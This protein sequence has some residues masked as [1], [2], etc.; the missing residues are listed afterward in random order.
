M[1]I[2]TSLC[3][4]FMRLHLERIPQVSVI[5]G[6]NQWTFMNCLPFCS[7][8]LTLEVLACIS[9]L[10]SNYKCLPI[11]KLWFILLSLVN[12]LKEGCMNVKLPQSCTTLCDPI[13]CS[14]PGSSIHEILQ[15]RILQWVAMPSSRESSWPRIEPTYLMSPA[16]AGGFF[17][18]SAT[19]VQFTHSLVSYSLWPT[20]CSTPG[21]PVHHQLQEL[22]QTHVHW[23]GDAI[24]PSHLL[25]YPSPPAFNLSQQQGLFQWVNSLHRVAR[26][27]GLEL[28]HQSFQW[29][30]SD[31]L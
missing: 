27:M 19:S 5:T 26:I 7:L 8:L 18:T 6:P 2:L 23:V 20:D 14:P 11:D 29:V 17:T 16:L 9:L 25:S 15:A 30:F 12:M 28:Q 3:I 22:V 13:D 10:I 31:F 24:Q 21:F 4:T 1:K